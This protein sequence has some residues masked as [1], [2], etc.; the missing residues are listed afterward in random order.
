VTTLLDQVQT[1]CTGQR[2]FGDKGRDLEV[3]GMPASSWLSPEGSWPAVRIGFVHCRFTDNGRTNSVYQVPLSYRDEPDESLAYAYVGEWEEPDLGGRTVWVYDALHDKQATPYWL[4]GITDGRRLDD[5]EFH[6]VHAPG[7]A[8]V[9][10]ENSPSLVLT[11]EQSNTSL[12][13]GD[14]AMLKVFRRLEPGTNPGVEIESA[15]TEAG[16]DLVPEVLGWV[17]GSWRDPDGGTATG[18]L[19]MMTVFQR[20]ATDGWTYATT[21]VRDLYAEGDL[22]ADEVGGDFAGESYRLGMTSATV[23]ADLAKALG[24][25][26][27]PADRIPAIAAGMRQRLDQAVEAVPE[28]GQYAAG[29]VA[30]FD[31]LAGYDRPIPVQRIH[32]D[33]HLGQTLRTIEGWKVIDFEGEPA[34]PLSERRAADTPV[35]DVAGMLRSFDYAARHLLA[36]DHQGDAQ[37]AYRAAEWSNRNRSAFCEGYAEVAGADPRDDDVLLRA[38]SADKVVYEVMYEARNRPTWLPIPLA[39]A[40]QISR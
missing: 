20:S 8:T 11:V 15:L 25:D 22:H 21:S 31:A 27:L 36:A 17:H 39:A 29:L 23:H 4:D 5:L 26:E 16:S 13:Y 28:L 6:P 12:I 19:A 32:G 40:A 35:K 2:W 33:Y 38:F 18:D 37:I 1:F 3:T 14:T 9:V 24:S 30:A 34:K 10:P 7:E